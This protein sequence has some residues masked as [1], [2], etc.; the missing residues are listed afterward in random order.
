MPIEPARLTFTEDGTPCSDAFGDV[1]H[2]RDGGFEQARHVFI[3]GNGLPERWQGRERFTIVETGFG[4]GLNFL[5]TWAAWR[6]DAQRCDRLHFVSVE[7]HPFRR[8]DLATLH[9]RWPGLAPLAAELQ[10]HWPVLTPGTHRL[11]LDAGRIVLTLLFGDALDLMPELQCRA[12]AF[13]LDGFSPATNPQ[14]WSTELLRELPRLA[15]PGATLATWS[16]TGAVRRALGDLGFRCEKVAGFGG[17]REMLRA[18]FGAAGDAATAGTPR[19]ALVIGAGLAGSSIANRLAERGWT[20]DVVDAAPEAAQGASGNLSGVLRP[21]PS[22]DDNRLARITR[23]GALYGLRH[24]HRLSARGLPVRWDACG[25]LHLARDPMHEEKQRRVVEAQQAPEEYLRFVASEEASRIAAWPLPLGGWWFPAGGWVNPPSLC[26]ANLAAFPEAIRCHFGRDVAALEADAGGW[27]ALDTD[28][29]VIA[30]AP[31]AILANGVGIRRFPQA[32]ALPVRSA[33]GQVSHLLAQADSAPR[34]VVCRLGYVSPAIDGVRSAGATFSVDDDDPAL[35]MSDHRENLAKLDFI[36]PGFAAAFDPT[37]LDG[38]V[39]FR[40]AS[41]DRL[42]MVGAVP[43]VQQTD[44]ASPLSSIPRHPGLYAVE[45]FGARGLVWAA[46]AAELLAS[47]LAGDP[48]P[49][50]RSLV[51]ALDPARYLLRPPRRA[52]ADE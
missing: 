22:L 49:L 2:S 31:V 20:V 35:R 47:E 45:G 9:A 4:L 14:L 28:G 1:Y 11:H 36:L 34:V 19:H 41:P 5:A 50:E 46:L 12:D 39:G 51:E 37:H 26:R 8:E 44:R 3:G 24:L 52:M 40:P 10:E 27:R 15:A 42:P 48:L 17:K 21:L 13:N 16:V 32:A 38:R 43:A 25:V 33:R 7:R 29:G 6:E 30:A 23:A 18:R